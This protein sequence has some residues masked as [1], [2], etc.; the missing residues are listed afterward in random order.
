MAL[1]EQLMAK[2]ND[3]ALR[4]ALEREVADLKKRLTWGLVFEEPLS[5]CVEIPSG[6][7]IDQAAATS[8]LGATWTRI[9][10]LNRA[11]ARTRVMTVAPPLR[12]RQCW[13]RRSTIL[14]TR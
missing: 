3:T 7:L 9:P 4:Q 6:S 11:P 14:N 10:S 2:V 5:S 8:S 1:V 13:P 12:T